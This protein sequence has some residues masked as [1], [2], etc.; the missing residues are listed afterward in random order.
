MS[1]SS[2]Q[3]AH[4]DLSEPAASSVRLHK[5]P[6]LPDGKPVPW[7]VRHREKLF[8]AEWLLIAA[9]LAIT[10]YFLVALL[11]PKPSPPPPAEAPSREGFRKTLFS[12]PPLAADSSWRVAAKPGRW[13]MIVV[14][15][16]ATTG[17]SPDVIDRYHRENNKWR[18][19]LG[20]HFLVGNGQ[21]MGD[22]EVFVGKRWTG[23][24]DGAHVRMSG[25]GNANS[26][27]IGVALVGD[28]QERLPTAR[29]LAALRG[30]VSFL[31]REYG[32]EP[33]RVVGHGEVAA[34]AT[35]CPGTFL[36]VD[37]VVRATE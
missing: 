13:N 11:L 16:T 22:G 1:A 35:K 34:Q 31:M 2:E 7:W 29:Q 20:Y 25:N 5:P 28:F 4:I 27:A 17:G 8:V 10:A 19:G 12:L 14:H 36:F 24:L 9:F 6:V 18:N 26:F 32:I 23:Q 37:E 30:L 15:H 33:S 3:T 21:G